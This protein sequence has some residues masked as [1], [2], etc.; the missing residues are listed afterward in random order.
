[1][2][3]PFEYDHVEPLAS[4]A[5][6]LPDPPIVR[7]RP[8][9]HPAGSARSHDVVRRAARATARTRSCVASSHMELWDEETAGRR[10][11]H[12]HLH[13]AGDGVSVRRRWSGDR[14]DSSA[15]PPRSSAATSFWSSLGGEHS[16]TPPLVVGRGRASIPGLS[17]LQ[18]DAHADLRDSLHGHA[19]QPRLRDAARRSS[20]RAST[21]V[22]IRSLSTEEAEAAADAEHDDLLRLQH[23]R[24]PELDR[25]ASSTRSATTS[26]SRSTCDG[27][28]PAIMPAIGTPEPGGLSWPEIA[29]AAARASSSAAGRRLRRRRAV[30]DS[31][32]GRAELPLRE[33][34]L[35]D[36]DV[37]LRFR[38]PREAA[39]K[40]WDNH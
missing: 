30:P 31:R 38:S 9:R 39:V 33:A 32:H 19:A 15:S 10:P 1:M 17:V 34:D 3:L 7:R 37:P 13:A 11:R 21:Q 35:Q 5:A 6:P 27:L 14:R 12:R 20:T 25:R 28:D 8:R 23:A 24:G 2:D 4:S 18:I 29:G 26:T 40:P 16:I 22:G 36:A